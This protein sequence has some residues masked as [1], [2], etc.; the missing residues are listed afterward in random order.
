MERCATSVVRAAR[1]RA[2]LAL[3]LGLTFAPWS[4]V[5]AD[6]GGVPFWLSGQYASLA[7]LPAT[8]GW[9]VAV[10]PY[11]YNGSASSSRTFQIGATAVSGLESNA[12]SLLVVPSYAPETKILGGQLS[13]A[14]AAGVGRNNSAVNLNLS[15]INAGRSRSDSVSGGTDLYPTAS[16]AWNSDNHNWMTYLT[17][18]IPTG[19][20]DKNRLA[21]LGIGHGAIDAGGGYTYFNQQNGRELSAVVGFTYNFENNDTQYKNGIDSHLDWAISQFLSASWHVGVAGY[22]Y[23]QLTGDSGSGNLVGS[24]KSCVAAAGPQVGYVF[25]I[26]GNQAYANAR[27]YKEFWAKNR[28]EGYMLFATLSISFGSTKK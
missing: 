19:A 2:A 16:L 24:F 5:R 28:V 23:Y 4:N 13:L 22:V 12:P 8:P 14:L 3:T 27:V 18:D 10:V 6:Q 17:G 25:K 26:M 7:A 15:P 20:Y 21:N 11:Y 9:S 1:T